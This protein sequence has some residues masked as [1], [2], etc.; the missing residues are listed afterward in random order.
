MRRSLVMVL[1]AVLFAAGVGLAGL[2]L[3]AHYF[4]TATYEIVVTH[5]EG[6]VSVFADARCVAVT[7]AESDIPGGRRFRVGPVSRRHLIVVV[8]RFDEGFG[9]IA[10][11][12]KW[13]TGARRRT[14]TSRVDGG[15][16]F[17]P[18]GY[19]AFDARGERRLSLAERR[20]CRLPGD[21]RPLEL[22]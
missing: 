3:A 15:E 17:F 6:E 13:R 2:A 18:A 10:I 5:Q 1:S 21:V 9:R 7:P 11:S 22:R 19:L 8:P 12:V 14:M 20:R 16:P 4:L